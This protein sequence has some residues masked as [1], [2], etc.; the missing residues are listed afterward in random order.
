M[1]RWRRAGVNSA[2]GSGH[3]D[4]DGSTVVR[5]RLNVLTIAEAL[6]ASFAQRIGLITNSTHSINYGF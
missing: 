2:A 6:V 1:R 3:E 5:M 4:F